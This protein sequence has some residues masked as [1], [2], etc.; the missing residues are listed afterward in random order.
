MA[1]FVNVLLQWL[2]IAAIVVVALLSENLY[3]LVFASV[4]VFGLIAYGFANPAFMVRRAIVWAS[5]AI[6][7]AFLL[8]EIPVEPVI[9]HLTP[10]LPGW[11]VEGTRLVLQLLD[12]DVSPWVLVPLVLLVAV[13]TASAFSGSKPAAE[14]DTYIMPGRPF[15]VIVRPKPENLVFDHTIVVTNRTADTIFINNASL[16]LSRFGAEATAELYESGKPDQVST[17]NPMVLLPDTSKALDVICRSPGLLAERIVGLVETCR[18]GWI[19]DFHV[20]ARLFGSLDEPQSR[21]KL[22]YKLTARRRRR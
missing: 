22:T 17:S 19:I 1:W 2:V 4:L 11:A 6:I 3:V 14:R 21:V 18:L 9:A 8:P 5:T 15:G 12:A 10:H 7:A 16:R 13:E 20:S